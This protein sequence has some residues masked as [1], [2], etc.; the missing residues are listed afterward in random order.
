MIGITFHQGG[1]YMPLTQAE[2]KPAIL[3]EWRVWPKEHGGNS[4]HDMT[5]F[6]FTWLPENRPGLLP[7]SKTPS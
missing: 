2:A 1:D 4:T 5:T 7:V 6:Y 3:D